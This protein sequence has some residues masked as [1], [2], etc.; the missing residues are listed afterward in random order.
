ME[1]IEIIENTKEARKEY[2]HLNGFSILELT[3]DQ[4]VEI[5]EFLAYQGYD[6]GIDEL[7][8]EYEKYKN[9]FYVSHS[10]KKTFEHFIFIFPRD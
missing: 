6:I 10:F 1:D 4:E 8:E 3:Q 9:Y 7:L 5:K 2:G